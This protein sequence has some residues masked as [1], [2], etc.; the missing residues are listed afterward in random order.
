VRLSFLQGTPEFLQS[1]K[2]AEIA[3]YGMPQANLTK[4][5]A[6]SAAIKA[7]AFP[8]AGIQVPLIFHVIEWED[9]VPEGAFPP[10]TDDILM[11]QYASVQKVRTF[12]QARRK[13][14][15]LF[16]QHL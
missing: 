8:N 5:K 4:A 16:C 2:A 15:L 7:S 1:L 3:I 12:P 9:R 13:I 6:L 14:Q 10:P 11:A